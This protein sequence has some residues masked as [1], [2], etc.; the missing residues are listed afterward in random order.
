MADW[1]SY[2]LSDFLLF[3]SSTYYRLFGLYN[4]DL[5]PAHLIVVALSL[6]FLWL[7]LRGGEKSGRWAC[8]LLAAA[9]AWTGWAFVWERYA[10]INW[11][12]AYVAPLF[13]VE[14][15]LLLWL[16]LKHPFLPGA[17]DAAGQAGLALLAFAVLL[18]PFV[19]I[20]LGRPWTEAELFGLAP[21]P[22]VVGTL[23]AALMLNSRTSLVL[24]PIPLLWCMLSGATL[25]TMGA[26]E[27][28]VMLAAAALALL[29]TVR[30]SI[31]SRSSAAEIA[32]QER[33][34]RAGRQ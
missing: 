25:W 12:A 34:E 7:I 10:T 13:A 22:T 3:S 1:L 29:L 33:D 32:L 27:A 18:Q 15:A 6:V 2:T 8:A 14:A 23:G 28:W 11:A 9:W 21:D 24:I 31:G 19:R 16:A 4:S 17:R 20:A 5:W 26:P 30:R